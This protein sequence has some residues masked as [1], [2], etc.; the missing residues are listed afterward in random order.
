MRRIAHSLILGLI[1]VLGWVSVAMTRLYL[2]HKSLMSQVAQVPSSRGTLNI[3]PEDRERL[4][5]HSRLMITKS[6]LPLLKRPL[7]NDIRLYFRLEPPEFTFP[8]DVWAINEGD[9]DWYVK[10]P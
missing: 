1:V 8:P 2:N 7:R 4:L 9:G 6:F 3:D 5:L 10:M